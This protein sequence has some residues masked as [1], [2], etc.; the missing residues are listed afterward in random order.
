[1]TPGGPAARPRSR[2]SPGSACPRSSRSAWPTCR[3]SSREP[4]A[5]AALDRAGAAGLPGQL[6]DGLSTYVGGP[7]TGGHNLSGGQWQKLALGRA[8]RSPD[9]LLVVL[10]EPTASLDAHAEHAL[11]ER[12]AAAAAALRGQRGHGHPAGLAPLRHRRGWPT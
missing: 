3:R 10:D 12:Y 8:M 1:M 4:L 2:T 5:L 7:Y 9:P 11:F 6:P